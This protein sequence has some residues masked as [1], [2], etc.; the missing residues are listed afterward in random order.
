MLAGDCTIVEVTECVGDSIG[1]RIN[2]AAGLREG[3]GEGAVS[4]C[5]GDAA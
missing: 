5:R 4:I 3:A 2:D 1:L